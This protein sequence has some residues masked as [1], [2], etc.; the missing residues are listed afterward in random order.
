[1]YSII[2][3]S[4][5]ETSF[6]NNKETNSS[7]IQ[8][9]SQDYEQDFIRIIRDVGI[10]IITLLA[11]IISA[12]FIVGSWQKTKEIS[13]I[14]KA[15]LENYTNSFTNYITLMDTFVAK[16]VM[17]FAKLTNNKPSNK[18]ALSE[19]LPWGF[20]F[21]DLHDYS[22][23]FHKYL[24]DDNLKDYKNKV[25]EKN[26]IE[27]K[28]KSLGDA[29]K[30]SYIDF[31][32]KKLNEFKNNNEAIFKNDFYQTRNKLMG[33]IANLSQY[34]KDSTHL[35]GEFSAMWEY[36]M[37]CYIL[38]NKILDSENEQKF[39]E[40]VN[41]YNISA[42]F[43]FDMMINYERKLIDRKINLTHSKFVNRINK[44]LSNID[45]DEENPGNKD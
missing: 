39:I 2:T 25:Y 22:K 14:R 9:Y 29:N 21:K 35:S 3:D 6:Q 45:N 26:E 10:P 30:E 13:D 11:G 43:L 8:T 16:L 38:V 41:E 37:A 42:E 5:F 28:F 12:K 1:M 18:T 44:I 27:E 7:N 19:L 15:I 32:H 4:S 24:T 34:Y 23:K 33:F 36:M 40:S 20:T 31:E 17:E